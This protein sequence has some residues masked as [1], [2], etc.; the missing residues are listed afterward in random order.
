MNKN[1][2]I[3][4]NFFYQICHTSRLNKIIDHYEIFKKIKNVKGD[5]YEFGVFKGAS[6]I[7]FLTFRDYFNLK[8]KVYGFDAYGKFPETKIDNCHKSRDKT[9]AK[10]HD[11]IAGVGLK[12]KK[13]QEI[14]KKK[15]FK[16]VELIQGD[17]CKT[18]NKF[19]N[20]KKNLNISLLHLDMDV[21]YPTIFVLEK[22]YKFVSKNGVVL[23]D[24][25][26]HIKGATIAINEFLKKNKKIKL[27]KL[28][29]SSRP[30][31]IIKS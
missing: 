14:L 3:H 4:E 29:K 1:P 20:K 9:F 5:I 13:L 28:S 23:I 25:Y 22:L 21:F 6:L 17:V 12:K 18:L 24:D 2:W 15:K 7:R 31:Y 26:G 8:K 11:K 27:L 19:L 10:Y 16:R 30:S